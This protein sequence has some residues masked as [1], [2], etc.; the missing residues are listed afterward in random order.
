MSKN[1]LGL[2]LSIAIFEYF[3]LVIF[4]IL[5]LHY[6]CLNR[7]SLLSGEDRTRSRRRV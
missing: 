7:L 2:E 3:A 1:K 6:F 5:Q 4:S